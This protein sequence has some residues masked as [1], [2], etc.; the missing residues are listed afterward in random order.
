M[1]F[2]F[3]LG[4]NVLWLGGLLLMFAA[5]KSHQEKQTDAGLYIQLSD[6]LTKRYFFEI[7]AKGTLD[8]MTSTNKKKAAK[9]DKLLPMEQ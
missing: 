8:N 7:T 4:F 6:W 1:G 2:W 5:D 9:E 3:G